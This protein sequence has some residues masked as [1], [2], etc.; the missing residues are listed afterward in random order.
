[1]VAAGRGWFRNG[2]DRHP[3]G[4]GDVLF[5]PAARGAPVRGVQR[6]PGRLGV[7]LRPRRRGGAAVSA[8]PADRR[9]RAHTAARGVPLGRDLRPG[10]GA[11]LLPRVG[12]RRPRGG[13][14]RAGRLRREGRRG[15]EHPGRPH[16]RRRAGARTTTS[17]ATAARS[18][19]PTAAPAASPAAIRCPYHSWTY[20][21]EGAAPHG[22]VP[23]RGRRAR[24]ERAVA[25]SRGRGRRG[26]ASSSSTSRRPRRRR[27]GTHWQP[28]SAPCPTGSAAIRWPSSGWRGGSPT[29]S[30]PTGR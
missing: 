1:M 3:F 20:T 9:A 5:V 17:A 24:A 14:G 2:D 7:L 4:P 15:R 21:L 22:A 8:D 11:D 30:R 16:P 6:R 27:A 13:A 19:C 29:R 12:L 28:S 10:E 18:W 25:P 23:R 26:A